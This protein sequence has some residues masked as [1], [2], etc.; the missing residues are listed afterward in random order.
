VYNKPKKKRKGKCLRV[1][2]WEGNWFEEIRDLIE[3]KERGKEG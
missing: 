1:G 2:W 3:E